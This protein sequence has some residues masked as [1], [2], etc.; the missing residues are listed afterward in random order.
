MEN[1]GRGSPLSVL[2]DDLLLHIFGLV[3]QQERCV[4][5]T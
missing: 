5:C 2:S 3:E 1:N 4:A